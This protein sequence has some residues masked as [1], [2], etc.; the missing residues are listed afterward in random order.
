MQQ[1]LLLSAMRPE[2]ISQCMESFVYTVLEPSPKQRKIS[3]VAEVARVAKN[4]NTTEIPLILFRE[5][6]YI[7]V[8]KLKQYAAK[9]EVS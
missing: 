9:M 7:A 3:S 8:T 6:P 1:L 2:R 4:L 5:E